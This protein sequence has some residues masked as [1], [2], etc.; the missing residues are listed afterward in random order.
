MSRVI[1]IGDANTNFS[2]T[3][4]ERKRGILRGHGTLL[5]IISGDTKR[6]SKVCG[7][8]GVATSDPNKCDSRPPEK[9]QGSG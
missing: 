1:L 9:C 5:R 6:P 8:D 4:Y 7:S 3:R 2:D